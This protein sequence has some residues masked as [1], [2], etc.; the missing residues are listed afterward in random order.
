MLSTQN[1]V[2]AMPEPSKIRSRLTEL[3]TEANFLRS[4][5]RLLEKNQSGKRLLRLRCVHAKGG[6]DDR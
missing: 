3:A 5:L 2:E 4:L 1:P 6:N